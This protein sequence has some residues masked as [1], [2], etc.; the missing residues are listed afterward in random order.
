M[1]TCSVDGCDKPHH[2]RGYCRVHYGR[3]KRTGSADLSPDVDPMTHVTAHADAARLRREA[4]FEDA[5]DLIAWGVHP[6]EVARR[7]GCT[8]QALEVQARRHGARDIEEYVRVPRRQRATKSC[9]DCGTEILRASTRCADCAY[10]A[11][12]V[13]GAA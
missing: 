6:D 3:I 4:R 1:S 11:R 12:W 8:R 2:A 9:P 10:I 13:K 5:R 7:V